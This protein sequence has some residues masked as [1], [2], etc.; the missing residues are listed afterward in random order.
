MSRTQTSERCVRLSLNGSAIVEQRMLEKRFTY[1]ALA[2]AAFTS[3]SS[4]K[5][6]MSVNYGVSKANFRAICNALG[7][8]DWESVAEPSI[9]V[10][11]TRFPDRHTRYVEPELSGLDENTT[12]ALVILSGSFPTKDETEVM[13]ILDILGKMLE[14]TPQ[15]EGPKAK[16]NG[17]GSTLY[18]HWYAKISSDKCKE[19]KA[20]LWHLLTKVAPTLK[21]TVSVL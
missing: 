17:K 4:V 7:L 3:L 19:T 6:F 15:I 14:D 18:L 2:K 9:L 1:E 13:M 20:H 5:R 8:E 11:S 16:S 10:D 12:G 21:L